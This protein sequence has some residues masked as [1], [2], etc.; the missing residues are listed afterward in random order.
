MLCFDLHSHST[1]SD[2]L[3]TPR[4]LVRRAAAKRV[5]VFA[6]TDHDEISGLHEAAA[7]A[8][9]AGIVFIPGTELSVSWR[10]LTLHIVGLAIDPDDATLHAGLKTIRE[11]RSTRAR[12][13]ADALAQAGIPGAYEGAMRYVTSESLV[14]RTHFARFLVEAGYVGEVR[15]V[16]KRY[17][18]PGKPGYVG[19][20]WATL[21]QAIAWIHGA[22]GQAVLAH[23]G[24]YPVNSTQMRE[25]LAE[26]KA[27]GGDGIEVLTSS[28]TPEQ[29]VEYATLARRF[30]F[31]ASVGSDYHG[32]GE[33]WM[34]LGELPRLPGGLVP[35]WQDWPCYAEERAAGAL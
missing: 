32:P 31:L 8:S 21:P 26:F 15:E 29:F 28:H 6:L 22:G 13:M 14:S 34:D 27:A 23:P 33:S 20:E 24:R 35:V 18:T 11:G 5:D 19:H 2:G 17:L 9:E 30:G 1:C 25:L 12:R 16:F 4:D 7:A 3:L 10:D